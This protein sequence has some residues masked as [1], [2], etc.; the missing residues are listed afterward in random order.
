MSAS[1]ASSYRR[2]LVTTDFSECALAGVREAARLATGLDAELVLAFVVPSEQPYMML[3]S[4]LHWDEIVAQHE[5]KAGVALAEYAA[6]HLARAGVKTVVASGNAASA[7][8]RLAEDEGADL[9]VIA[10]RGHGRMGR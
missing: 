1:G 5:E 7:I 6:K 9:I 8:A 3:G 10:S 2:I 4:G